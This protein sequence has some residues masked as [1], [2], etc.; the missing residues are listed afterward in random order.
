M[1]EFCFRYVLSAAESRSEED[2]YLHFPLIMRK[3]YATA[4]ALLRKIIK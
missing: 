2:I 4:P 1:F 3:I